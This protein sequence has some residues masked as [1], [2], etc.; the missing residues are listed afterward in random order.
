VGEQRRR[1][2]VGA[3]GREGDRGSGISRRMESGGQGE[4]EGGR[5][6]EK[7]R[8]REGGKKGE[9]LTNMSNKIDACEVHKTKNE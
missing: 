7:E 9:S 3:G 2:S 5:G 8:G 4:R 6:G 1:A